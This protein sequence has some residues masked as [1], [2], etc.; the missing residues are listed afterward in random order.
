MAVTRV[1]MK[2]NSK[3]Y[4]VS[5]VVEARETKRR[6]VVTKGWEDGKKWRVVLWV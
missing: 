6:M 4:E 2:Y 3:I 5:I 1:D